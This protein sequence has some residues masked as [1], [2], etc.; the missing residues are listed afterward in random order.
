MAQD[1]TKIG[2]VQ[3]VDLTVENADEVRDFYKAVVGW[4]V[5]GCDMGGYEDYN[6][7]PPGSSEPVAG[8]I[9]ARG[10]NSGLP[11]QWLM[12]VPVKDLETSA[13][14]VER[15]GGKIIKRNKQHA[16]IQDPGGAYMVI[17]QAGAGA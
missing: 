9:H 17:W 5:S 13:A 8:V 3:W 16:V 4:E 11:P 7:V 10:T 2:T 15:L 14:T 6:M 12:Y 1:L